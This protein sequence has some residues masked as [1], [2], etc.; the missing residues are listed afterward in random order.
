[1]KSILLI[2]QSNMAGR[3]YLNDVSP[4]LDERI[5]VLKNGRWQMMDEPIH[6][7][8]SVAG[9]GLAAS[10][11][12]LWLDDH[13]YETIGLIPCADGGTSMDDWAPEGILARHAIT[14]AQFA[15]ETSEII[16]ILWHQGE[17][18]SFN[19]QYKTYASKLKTLIDHFRN[20][21]K[22]PEVPFVLG[23]L[24]DFLGKSAF[25]QSAVEYKEINEALQ[26]TA[27]EKDNCYY[28]TAEG[29]TSNPDAIHINA[30]SQR[31]FGI[32]YYQAF[33]KSE[34]VVHPLPEETQADILLYKQEQTKNEELYM[35]VAQFSKNEIIYEKFI[36][37]MKELQ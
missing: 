25:G 21:L 24:P 15:Q 32:R 28:V 4:V 26:Q 16:G 19:Q 34:H 5:M 37:S 8:R 11:A 18:D 22:I 30:I 35:L 6:S 20:T 33:A 9:V 13:P 2:G 12:K 36:K 3:G 10:F 14:E 27:E 31:L 17:S 23:L 7:D 1:M 29:L